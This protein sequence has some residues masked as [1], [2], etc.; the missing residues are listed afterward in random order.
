MFPSHSMIADED[1]LDMAVLVG[2]GREAQ[3]RPCSR[4]AASRTSLG[5]ASGLVGVW[6]G[7]TLNL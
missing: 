6:V 2:A 1:D 7:C 4:M 3:V 5:P